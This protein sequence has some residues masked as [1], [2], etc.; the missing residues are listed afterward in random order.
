MKN[1][2]TMSRGCRRAAAAT[3]RVAASRNERYTTQIA[4]KMYFQHPLAG[5]R[6]GDQVRAAQRAALHQGARLAVV[7][8]AGARGA[9]AQRAPR[10]GGAAQ[11]DR[12]ARGHEGAPG[13]VR[14][15]ET[16][17]QAAE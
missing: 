9:A 1:C 12:G 5:A 8:A 14:G 3:W 13:Q 17:A 11:A 2:R 7:A 10:R 15:R 4:A 16:Q 6:G